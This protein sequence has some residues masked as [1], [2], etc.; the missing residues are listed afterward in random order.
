MFGWDPRPSIEQVVAY[1]L[2][3]V[4]AAW[5]SLRTPRAAPT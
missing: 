1:L 2:F 4:T 5:L 3:I